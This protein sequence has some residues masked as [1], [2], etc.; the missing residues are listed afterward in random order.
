LAIVSA[1]EP[2]EGEEVMAEAEF[3]ENV[4]VRCDYTTDLPNECL[5]SIFHFLGFGDRK[6]CSLNTILDHY[7]A[8]EE[9]SVK[10]LRGLN[11]SADPIGP[12]TAV[13]SLKSI[14]LKELINGQTGQCFEPLIVGSVVAGGVWF[15]VRERDGSL[16]LKRRSM[17]KFD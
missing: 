3:F 8:L 12:D 17:K 13:S 11:D 6:Q 2:N 9:L 4:V 15:L 7:T 14:Y 5:A 1:F 10:R 16:C